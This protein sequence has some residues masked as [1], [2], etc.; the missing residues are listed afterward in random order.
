MVWESCRTWLMVICVSNSRHCL[1]I[2]SGKLQMNWI[3]RQQRYWRN[4]KKLEIKLY[5]EW[6]MLV[7]MLLDGKVKEVLSNIYIY[8]VRPFLLYAF[9]VYNLDIWICFFFYTCL[10]KSV[11]LGPVDI[12]SQNCSHWVWQ[13]DAQGNNHSSWCFP[14]SIK[15]LVLRK[16][17]NCKLLHK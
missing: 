5:E 2:C 14:S 9:S 1:W 8:I 10:W 11:L 4:S 3:E 13:I 6:K 12:M 16:R 17:K 15:W 7:K